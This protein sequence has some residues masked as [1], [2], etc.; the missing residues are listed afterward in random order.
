MLWRC[1][2]AQIAERLH[3]LHRLFPF[4]IQTTLYALRLI[5]NQN[6]ASCT[7]QI[8]WLFT[9]C[10]FAWSIHDIF[11]CLAPF[12]LVQFFALRF[13]FIPKLIYGANRHDHDLNLWAGGKVANLT[14]FGRIV[15]KMIKRNSAVEP[16]QMF[17][18]NFNCVRHAFLNGNRRHNNDKLCK[19]IAPVQLKDG[20]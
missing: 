15:N 6:G 3:A 20:S 16:L 8:D 1:R 13:L 12:R 5:N 7:N 9:T 18:S 19:A 2:I 10:L 17:G 11:T 14:K 4:A